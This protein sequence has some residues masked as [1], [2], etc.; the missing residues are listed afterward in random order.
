M[1]EQV[2]KKFILGTRRYNVQPSRKNVD[3]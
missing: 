3:K 1:S 2:N